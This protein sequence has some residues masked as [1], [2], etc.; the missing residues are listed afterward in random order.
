MGEVIKQRLH[1]LDNLKGF[2]IL[3]VI[4]GH[5]VQ[6]RIAGYE[7]NLIFRIVYSFHMP[8]FFMIS[9][10]LSHK[11]SPSIISIIRKRAYQLLIPY[12]CF[13]IYKCLSD[14]LPLYTL[15]TDVGNFLWFLW[16]LFF[17]NSIVVL[18][19]CHFGTQPKRFI[20]YS[21]MLVFVLMIGAKVLP[22][23]ILGTK[24]ICMNLQY[25]LVGY[26][27]HKFDIVSKINRSLL[28]FLVP[29]SIVM[30]YFW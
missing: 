22:S 5:C 20:C 6:Y 17:I 14:G 23:D 27:L 24:L 9:G 29:A 2:A 10:Y 15:F 13:G 21:V 4:L 7:Y 28:F 12:F 19:D 16:A 18:L 1:Y 11:S 25:F 30:M 3:M 26:V 8:L